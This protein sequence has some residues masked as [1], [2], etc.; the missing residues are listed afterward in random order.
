MAAISVELPQ[1][2][3][4]FIDVNIRHGKFTS[5][6]DYIVALVESARDGRSAIEAALLEGLE[7]GPAEE[8]TKD[9]WVRIKQCVAE[10][11]QGR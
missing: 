6:N 8:W 5:A 2:L 4:E 11:H 1:D 9:E 10:R 7:S 3:R